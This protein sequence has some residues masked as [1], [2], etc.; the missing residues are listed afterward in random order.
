MFQKSWFAAERLLREATRWVFIG[1]SLPSADFEF[2]YLLKR[3]QLCRTDRPEIIVVSGGDPES[4]DRT[5]QNYRKF[6]GS[7]ISKSNF[8]ENGLLTFTP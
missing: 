3:M 2:K 4:L 1:Y 8:I 5:R 6:F 7:D